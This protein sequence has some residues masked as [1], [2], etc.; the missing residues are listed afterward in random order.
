MVIAGGGNVAVA[1]SAYY[2][3]EA[4]VLTACP[5]VLHECGE[6]WHPVIKLCCV[7]IVGVDCRRW[8]FRRYP[9]A[10]VAP[11]RHISYQH[12][13]RSNLVGGSLGIDRRCYGGGIG[14]CRWRISHGEVVDYGICLLKEEVARVIAVEVCFDIQLV[15]AECFVAT[16]HAEKQA[17]SCRSGA[18]VPHRSRVG[19][20]WNEIWSEA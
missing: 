16:Y 17:C 6:V 13:C 14:E 2:A 5:L 19:L 9:R 15:V 11:L 8:S 18:E 10:P 20:H 1:E 4:Q 3:A 12:C 7:H